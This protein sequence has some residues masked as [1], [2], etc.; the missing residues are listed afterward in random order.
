MNASI[1][2]STLA[3]EYSSVLGIRMGVPH[4]TKFDVG[5]VRRWRGFDIGG[6]VN[7]YSL[8]GG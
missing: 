5:S 1:Q 4:L 8:Q 6:C 3:S 7:A 2:V